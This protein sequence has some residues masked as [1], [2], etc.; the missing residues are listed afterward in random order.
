MLGVEGEGQ[1]GVAIRQ[2]RVAVGD[3]GGESVV[4]LAKLLLAARDDAANLSRGV[5]AP[6][7]VV[8]G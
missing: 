5:I 6:A 3:A 8:A 1:P 4:A 7:G 2:A